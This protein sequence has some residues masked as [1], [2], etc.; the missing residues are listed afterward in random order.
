M[1][2]IGVV[3]QAGG[4]GAAVGLLVAYARHRDDPDA[5]RWRTVTGFSLV[6]LS[7]GV[8]VVLGELLLSL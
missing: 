4:V 6:G 7:G 3:L 1:L 2:T 8:L 5:D